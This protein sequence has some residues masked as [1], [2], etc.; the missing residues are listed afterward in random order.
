MN[1]E[2]VA[3]VMAGGRGTRMA[4]THPFAPKSLVHVAGVPLLQVVLRQLEAASVHDV[5]LAV[6]HEAERICSWVEALPREPGTSLRCIVEDEPL[7]TVGALWH[8]RS[9]RRTVAVM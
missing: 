4:R 3:L 7:G 6:R 5:V 1:G 2:V 8:L 9:E